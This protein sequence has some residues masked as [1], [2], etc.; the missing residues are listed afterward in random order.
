MRPEIC[1][2][3]VGPIYKELENHFSV[4]YYPP[5]LGTAKNLFFI[6]HD[7]KEQSVRETMRKLIS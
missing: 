7:E 5:V 6:N 4:Y 2:L 1:E 3:I